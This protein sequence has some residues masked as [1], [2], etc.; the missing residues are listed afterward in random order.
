MEVQRSILAKKILRKYK[1]RFAISSF[2][3]Y[4]RETII[5]KYYGTGVE[6]YFRNRIDCL[7]TGP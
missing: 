5:I 6:K 4:Y 1:V 2:Q 7:E 3:N